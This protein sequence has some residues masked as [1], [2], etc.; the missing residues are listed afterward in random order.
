VQEIIPL[1]GCRCLFR[2]KAADV[3]NYNADRYFVPADLI[4]FFGRYRIAI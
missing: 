1:F 4:E 3:G 2:S